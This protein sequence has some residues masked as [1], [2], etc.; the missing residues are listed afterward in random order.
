MRSHL[1]KIDF[2]ST[3]TYF[4]VP[5]RAIVYEKSFVMP[6]RKFL[7]VLNVSLFF[8]KLFRIYIGKQQRIPI[9]KMFGNT[10]LDFRFL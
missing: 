5:F 3:V 4:D 7:Q 6:K 10:V 8:G 9:N 2:I 1:V